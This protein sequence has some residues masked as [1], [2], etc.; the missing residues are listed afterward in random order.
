MCRC[1]DGMVRLCDQQPFLLGLPSPQYEDHRSLLRGNQLNNTISESLP[2]PSLVR[3][4][5]AGLDRENRI[6]HKDTLSSPGF[7]IP[8]IGNPA[9]N[10]VMEFSVNVS[11]GEGQRP[12]GGLH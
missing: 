10:I 4:S 2:A 8:V 1:N 11:Q 3:I 5:L 12:D 6:E 7:Q 9:S